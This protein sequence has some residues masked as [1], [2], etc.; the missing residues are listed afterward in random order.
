MEESTTSENAICPDNGG[1]IWDFVDYDD[2]SCSCIS[3]E[4][5]Q[6]LLDAAELLGPDCLPGTDDDFNPDCPNNPADWS[7]E[8]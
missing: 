2:P 5:K 8:Q 3:A 7:Y 1:C 4:G 6:A